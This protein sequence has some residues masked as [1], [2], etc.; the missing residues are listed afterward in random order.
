MDPRCAQADPR[1]L[2][3][4]EEDDGCWRR[5]RG[6]RREMGELP[7]QEG[8]EPKETMREN[9]TEGLTTSHVQ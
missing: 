9:G 4:A 5:P 6:R 1:G 8:K 2:E 7:S 3:E